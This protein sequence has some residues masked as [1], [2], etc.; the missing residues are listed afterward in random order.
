MAKKLFTIHRNCYATIDINVSAETEEE[1]LRIAAGRFDR[2]PA[3]EYDFCENEVSVIDCNEMDDLDGLMEEFFQKLAESDRDG[4]SQIDFFDFEYVHFTSLDMDDQFNIAEEVEHLH[5]VSGIS[6]SGD[7]ISLVFEDC[8]A[9]VD[10]SEI[11][12]A[13]QVAILKA[14]IQ[15]L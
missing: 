2:I 3:K 14:A 6:V 5:A 15:A 4:D 7:D 9:D 10:I 8:R 11:D 12:Y 13:E 1:A